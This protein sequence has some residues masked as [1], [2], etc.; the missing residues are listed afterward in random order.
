MRKVRAEYLH[1]RELII[2]VQR[3]FRALQAMRRER[4]QYT[5]IR[6]SVMVL[7]QRM[8]ALLQGRKTREDLERTR[9]VVIR[10]QSLCRGALARA[11]YKKL[12]YEK[13]SPE[14]IELRK[15]NAAALKIQALWRGYRARKRYQSKAMRVVGEKIKQSRRVKQQD[16]VTVKLFLG[17]SMLRLKLGL[18]VSDATKIFKSLGELMSD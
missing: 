15:R 8:R 2:M 16:R 17:A 4:T 9:R 1:R 14:A 10:M 18:N 12:W 6:R 11:A 3:R 7:Q 5:M 13:M